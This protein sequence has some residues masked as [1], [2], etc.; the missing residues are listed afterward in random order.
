MC[1]TWLCFLPA[2]PL[3]ALG[4]WDQRVLLSCLYPESSLGSF[5]CPNQK[6]SLGS[7]CGWHLLPLLWGLKDPRDFFHPC[8]F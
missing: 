8:L 7:G 4:S 3:G 2:Q 5:P 6:V 1:G